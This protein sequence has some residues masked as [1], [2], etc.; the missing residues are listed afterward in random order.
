MDIKQKMASKN[1]ISYAAK[2]FRENVLPTLSSAC[3]VSVSGVK[4]NKKYIIETSWTQK[5]FDRNKSTLFSYFYSLSNE[6]P[7]SIYEL[8]KTFCFPIKHEGV[9]LERVSF[10]LSLK[11]LILKE[12][13]SVSK[14]DEF[15]LEVW[16]NKSMNLIKS[17]NL[18][19]CEK[20][21]NVLSDSV[22]SS[23]EWSPD[24]DKLVY[25]AE[26]KKPKCAVG[27]FEMCNAPPQED[28]DKYLVSKFNYEESWGEQMMDI[29]NPVICVVDIMEGAV[30]VISSIPDSISPSQPQWGPDGTIIFEAIANYPFRLG[31]VY[32]SNRPSA[33][34]SVK[35]KS[36]EDPVFITR[37][38][39]YEANYCPRVSP[40]KT[41]FLYIHRRLSGKGDPHQGAEKLKLY[42]FNTQSSIEIETAFPLYIQNL[43]KSCWINNQD[44]IIPNMEKAE[45]KAI[46]IN[47]ET[48]KV[49]KKVCCSSILD[50]QNDIAVLSYMALDS[51]EAKLSVICHG[52]HIEANDYSE[53]IQNIKAEPFITDGLVSWVL[54]LKESILAKPLIVW[55][56]G[57]P[58]SVICNSYNHY[59]QV[60]CKLGYIVLLVNYNGSTSFSEESLLSLP[61]KVG[62]QDVH[63]VHST[64]LSYISA[65][66]NAVDRQNVYVFGGSHGGFISAH[67]I[68]QYPDFYCAAALRNPVIEIP[69]MSVVSDIPDWTYAVSGLNYN[70]SNIPNPEVYKVMLEKSPIIHA[71]KIKAPVLLCVGGKDARVPPSQSINFFKLLKSLDKNV[72]M[73]LYPDDSHPLSSV[74]TEGDVFVNVCLW[75]NK[76]KRYA[77]L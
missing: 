1:Y 26:K 22:F 75:F 31:I 76:H 52:E 19:A 55:P 68:G 25:V 11:A 12:V 44:V 33:L 18:T 39:E 57:G 8:K 5:C 41:K 40:C 28:D 71:A 66:E 59:A 38:S 74:E 32:C 42:L 24:E 45:N 35:Y 23:L 9:L 53:K 65:N 48:L 21:G 43:P 77:N 58:H 6:N 64:V 14:K 13:N 54:S 10:S 50:A 63:D 47:T 16:S 7:N 46:I 17:I 49:I 30:N 70:P 69:S 61:G 51:T 67:L 29:I 72:Q 20:H 56:H 3:V 4:E 27:I 62:A 2:V 37:P 15:I 73:M 36:H 34:C 60:F